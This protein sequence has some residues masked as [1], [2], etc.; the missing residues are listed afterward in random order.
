MI[1]KNFPVILLLVAILVTTLACGSE[2]TAAPEATV[3]T[4]E[5]PSVTP[6]IT[7]PG[8]NVLVQNLCADAEKCS[9]WALVG[10]MNSGWEAFYAQMALDYYGLSVADYVKLVQYL[11]NTFVDTT[12]CPAT[13]WFECASQKEQ[14]ARNLSAGQICYP[15]VVSN[16]LSVSSSCEMFAM[17]EPISTISKSLSGLTYQGNLHAHKLAQTR[18]YLTELDL[19][20]SILYLFQ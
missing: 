19:R 20:N 8:I 1:S 16:S 3:I 5:P 13:T 15:Q 14:N 9:S 11:G 4:K 18:F 2:P 10:E 7:R 6:P 12:Y 17:L